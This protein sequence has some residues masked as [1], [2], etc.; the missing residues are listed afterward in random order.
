MTN[1]QSIAFSTQLSVNSDDKLSLK[2][3]EGVPLAVAPIP[4]ALSVITSGIAFSV[5]VISGT[6]GLIH[7]IAVEIIGH[8]TAVH[9]IEETL[10]CIALRIAFIV[11]K[12]LVTVFLKMTSTPRVLKVDWIHFRLAIESRIRGK[13]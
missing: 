5:S 13:T 12:P 6:V 2:R 9:T 10:F 1:S 7:L 3:R 4:R 11:C 8:Q